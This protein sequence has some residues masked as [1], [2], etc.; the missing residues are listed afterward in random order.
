MALQLA[1]T[2]KEVLP[3]HP[4]VNGLVEYLIQIAG[5]YPKNEIIASV[6]TQLAD[7]LRASL[8]LTEN[9]YRLP[10]LAGPTPDGLNASVRVV[11]KPC[12]LGYGRAWD[13]SGNRMIE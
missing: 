8:R 5:A 9:V 1:Q 10:F 4:D 12:S 3:D 2:A 7:S 6:A 13:A 11:A